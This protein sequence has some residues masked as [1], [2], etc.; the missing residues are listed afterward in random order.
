[1]EQK[2]IKYFEGQKVKLTYTSGFNLIGTILEVY[3]DS[4]LFRTPQRDSIVNIQEIFSIV[5]GY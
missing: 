1:M 4:I 3:N 5:G 2:A